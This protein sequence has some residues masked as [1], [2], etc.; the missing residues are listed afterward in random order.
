MD[1]YI[2]HDDSIESRKENV[3]HIKD[4]L[5]NITQIENIIVI[6][7]FDH[8]TIN[9]EAVKK[10]LRTTKPENP[11]ET[12]TL[13]DKFISPMNIN[14]ISNYL[15]HIHAYEGIIKS[16]KAAIIL[17]DDVIISSE[18]NDLVKALHETTHDIVFCG[19]P[20]TQLPT[21]TFSPIKNL[22]NMTLLPSCESYFIRPNV[23]SILI[24]DMLPIVYTTNIAI[25]ASISAHNMDAYKMY[26][27]AFIDGS[28]LG[29]YTSRINNNNILLFNTKY[30][31]L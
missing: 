9:Q 29:K 23:A 28:K 2:I 7:T 16:Q 4:T 1:I 22:T 3:Q 18:I 15:K 6:N 11:T 27:N 8:K 5:K 31:E 12:D 14:N 25:S 17:E 13:F 26:P 20:F 19:Q 24:K 10:V 30:N 21:E